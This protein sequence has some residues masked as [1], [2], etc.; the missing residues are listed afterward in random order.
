MP[1]E[2]PIRPIQLNN[3]IINQSYYQKAE[4]TLHNHHFR[5]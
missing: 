1:P 4:K 2:K 5:E 3:T